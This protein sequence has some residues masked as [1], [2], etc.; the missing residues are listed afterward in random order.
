MRERGRKGRR[1]EG[2]EACSRQEEKGRGKKRGRID[3]AWLR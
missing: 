3:V 1:I 2:V